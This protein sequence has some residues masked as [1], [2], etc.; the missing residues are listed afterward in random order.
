MIFFFKSFFYCQNYT[1][2]ILQSAQNRLLVRHGKVVNAEGIQDVDIYI[3][4]GIIK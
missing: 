3:E 2:G 1:N 4:D